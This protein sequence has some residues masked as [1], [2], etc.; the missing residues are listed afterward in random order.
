MLK[1]TI[2]VCTLLVATLLC[3]QPSEASNKR[4][5][6]D[7]TE[8]EKTDTVR[9][10]RLT[11]YEKLFRGKRSVTADGGFMKL[12]I[13]GKKLYFEMPLAVMGKEMLLSTTVTETTDNTVATNGYKPQA[14]LHVGFS[15]GDSVVYMHRINSRMS[16]DENNARMR[17]L[18]ERNFGNPIVSSYKLLAYN[19]DS[20]AVVFDMSNLFNGS[21]NSV[22][23]IP[24]GGFPI[25][26]RSSANKS[27]VDIYDVKSFDDNVSVKTSMTY[28]VSAKSVLGGTLFSDKPVTIKVTRTLMLLPEE[29]MKPRI[30]DSRL[31]IFLTLKQHL[32]TDGEELVN[33]S[34]ANRWRLIPS[35]TAAYARGEKVTPVKP[36]VFYVDTL[37][38]EPWVAPVKA[39]ALR[40][41]KAFERIGFKEVIQVRNFPADD[42]TFDPD[43]LKYSCIRYVPSAVA[44]AMGPSW[45]DPRTG[46][47]LNASVLIYNDVIK[48]LTQW[49]FVQT[50]QVDPRVRSKTLPD[51]VMFESLAYVV[52]HEVGHTLGL[53]HNMAA[54]AAYPVEKLRDP[55]FTRENGTTPS[56]MDYARFNYIAQ[57]TDTEVTLTPPELGL[58]DYY[59]I[60]WLYTWFPG[61]QSP[62]EE[63]VTLESWVDEKAGD[64]IYRYG[65]QQMS[66]RYDPSA[67]EEDLGDDPLK[68]SEYG[69][70]NLRY[71]AAHLNEWITDDPTAEYRK[72]L[73]AQ[74]VKQYGRYV[75]NVLYNVGGI[76]LSEAKDGT[77]VKRF[78]SVPRA[79]QKASLQWVLKQI[80]TNEW[81]DDDNICRRFG[82]NLKY[83]PDVNY[84]L[85]NTLTKIYMNVTLSSFLAEKDPYTVAEF[86]GDLYR[87]VWE[88]A[89]TGR[90]LTEGDKILQKAFVKMM[91]TSAG[92]IGAKKLSL[93]DGLVDFGEAYAPT[94]DQ[95]LLYGLDE[96]GQV[97]RYASILREVE[98]N[99]GSRYVAEHLF[100]TNFG[101][102]YGWQNWVR[103]TVI[104]ES[105][106]YYLDM[107]I[108]VRDL[109][110]R[111]IS[112]LPTQDRPH[113]RAMLYAVQQML[114]GAQ[115]K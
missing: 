85:A 63:A 69:V 106:V 94:V 56:I 82:L 58:Y 3:A 30:S 8:Q 45:V 16:C 105:A 54:S 81:L 70:K 78:E 64:P 44:N 100:E 72:S 48:R 84:S 115:Y 19:K 7:R 83:S 57:P 75:N 68:A 33:Y 89:I 101:Y 109:L 62:K 104:D 37:F 49:R 13:V 91:S 87:G 24:N 73:Y 67:M 20:T 71:I 107:M 17:R 9:K 97:D 15:L 113:Y 110:T 11:P 92:T 53:M 114:D 86:F 31:G 61:A 18:V 108:K 76:Y 55:A 2:F 21:D 112:T 42:P 23:P 43:N 28:D 103:S 95:I 47:I 93:H 98:R 51:E 32:P 29:P 60:K 111:R 35:D 66:S 26:L 25:A 14:P 39:G 12:H 102:G 99:E 52:A 80:S 27:T 10:P 59:A 50:A 65:K 46:E 96:G 22:S 74:I 6:K 38:P 79:R 36:I 88:S 90:R 41:N 34:L 77:K 4:K 1:K 5:K 40:W